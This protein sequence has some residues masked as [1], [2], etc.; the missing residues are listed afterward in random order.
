MTAQVVP[1]AEALLKV[2]QKLTPD[3]QKQVFDFA[4]F[5][6][7]R[8]EKENGS[9]TNAVDSQPRPRLLGLH[10]GQ[11]WIS[12]DFDEPLPDEFW[13]GEN[14]PLMMTDEQIQGLNQRSSS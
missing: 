12:E 5:L 11:V 10:T 4:E 3:R 7:Q 14:D 9:L 1:G 2:L 6:V 8:Q 13:L